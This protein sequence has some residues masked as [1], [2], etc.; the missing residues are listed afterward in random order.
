MPVKNICECENP[1]GG[2]IV[3]EPYQMAICG[4][5]HGVVRRECLDPPSGVSP[6]ALAN[7]AL[8]QISGV[9]LSMRS[10]VTENDLSTLISG[11][12]VSPNEQIVNFTIPDEMKMMLHL[13]MHKARER[14][15]GSASGSG[16]AEM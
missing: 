16:S 2:Q 1:P 9:D 10:I 13:I 4:V 15:E 5:I 8:S 11:T 3:C 6:V 12:F 14:D 7:W